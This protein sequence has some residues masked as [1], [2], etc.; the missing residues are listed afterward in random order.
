MPIEIRPYLTHRTVVFV[1]DDGNL[2]ADLLDHDV[3]DVPDLEQ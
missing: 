2:R 3:H 1:I